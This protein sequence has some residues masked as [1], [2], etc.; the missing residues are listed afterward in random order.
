M[1]NWSLLQ[2][3]MCW[4]RG[5]QLVVIFFSGILETLGGEVCWRKLIPVGKSLMII[6]LLGPFFTLCFLSTR[7][8]RPCTQAGYCNQAIKTQ[9]YCWPEPAGKKNSL[10]PFGHSIAKVTNIENWNKRSGII[11]VMYALVLKCLALVSGTIWD[12]L[13]GE[14]SRKVLECY[15]QNFMGIL[16]ELKNVT[17]KI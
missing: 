15:K 8:Q 4:A 12:S 3:L 2:R 11:A 13:K 16:M 1:W 9:L 14:P 10:R 7:R 6:L 17:Q 5:S